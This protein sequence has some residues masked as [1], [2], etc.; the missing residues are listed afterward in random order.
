MI[1]LK[2]SKHMKTFDM[3]VYSKTAKHIKHLICMIILELWSIIW[4]VWLF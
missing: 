1:I 2:L 3:Y 4:Y